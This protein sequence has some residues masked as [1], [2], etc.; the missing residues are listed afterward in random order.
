MKIKSSILNFQLLGSLI[1]L[2]CFNSF[3]FSQKKEIDVRNV[4]TAEFPNVKGN[5]WIRDPNG[6]DNKTISFYENDKRVKI[7]FENFKRSDSV[8]KQKTIL[9]LVLNTDNKKQREWYKKVIQ[10][11][12]QSEGIKK[13]DKVEIVSFSC[14]IDDQIIY[15]NKFNFTDDNSEIDG[16]L[17]AIQGYK[18]YAN[19]GRVQTHLALNDA[20]ALL[21]KEVSDFPTG[22]IILSDDKSLSPELTGETPGLRARRLDIPIYGIIYENGA[23][24]YSIAKLCEQTY[25]SYFSDVNNSEIDASAKLTDYLSDFQTKQAGLYFPFSYISNIKKGEKYGTVKVDSRKG[26]TI[27]TVEIPSKSFIELIKDNPL[28]SSLIGLLVVGLVVVIILMVKKNNLKQAELESQRVSKMLEV[29]EQQKS[30][31]QKI[32]QQEQ[33]IQRI[34]QEEKRSTEEKKINTQKEAEQK[35]DEAQLQKMLEKGNLP[36]FE[37]KLGSESGSYQIQSPRL[38]VGRDAMNMWVINHPTVSKQ[39]FKLTFR[40]SVYTLED[41]GSTNGTFINGFKLNQTIISHGDCIQI[42]DITLTIHL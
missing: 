27:F 24:P 18:N 41:L 34:Q 38:T 4:T 6:I 3:L 11:V 36:W 32:N 33:E 2:L 14:F 22:I 39:H 20:L 40:N 1:V 5:L 29:E 28:A 23:K 25:G 7:N 10:S 35:D 42:G 16:K 15:P 37:F 19:K 12:C 17:E 9:F 21:E 13:G 26:Q 31:E 8:A 30:S